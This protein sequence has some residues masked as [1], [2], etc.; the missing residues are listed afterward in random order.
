VVFE[1][2]EQVD[3]STSREYGGTGLGLSIVR[4]MVHLLGGEVTLQSSEG[5]GSTLYAI[6]AAELL[7]R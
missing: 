1:A 5:E 4:E 2:F 6:F 7:G 3:G